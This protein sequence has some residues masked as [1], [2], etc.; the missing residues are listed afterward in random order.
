MAKRNRNARSPVPKTTSKSDLTRIKLLYGLSGVF[1]ICVL[2]LL[3]ARPAPLVG[4]GSG[5]PALSAAQDAVDTA[6]GTD[7]G[8]D[9][10][11]WKRIV[12]GRT[13]SLSSSFHFAVL[14]R[15]S[16]DQIAISTEWSKQTDF[17]DRPGDLRIML[18]S[19][20]PA[21]EPAKEITVKRLVERLQ[22]RLR[23]DAPDILWQ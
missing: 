22:G 1:T 7:R 11:L 9:T 6:I 5:S 23:I 10:K 17:A 2:G 3:V 16:G 13:N 21:Q 19:T 18:V 15:D 14:P 20:D 12:I 8:I 4:A